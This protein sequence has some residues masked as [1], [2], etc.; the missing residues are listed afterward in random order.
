MPRLLCGWCAP[1][2]S[3]CTLTHAELDKTIAHFKRALKKKTLGISLNCISY[4]SYYVLGV[5]DV[6]Q[7]LGIY[8]STTKT[9]SIGAVRP[10]PP[11]LP[12]KGH[13][14]CVYE[15][16]WMALPRIVCCCGD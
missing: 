3:L 14:R 7:Q 4:P 1:D 15:G 11:K 10:P 8:T 12:C 5:L 2:R 9:A 6:L 16:C 13:R